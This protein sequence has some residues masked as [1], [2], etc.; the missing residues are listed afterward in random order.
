MALCV[1]PCLQAE[2]PTAAWRHSAI[3]AGRASVASLRTTNQV[4]DW[5]RTMRRN[6]SWEADGV[7]SSVAIQDG[8]GVSVIVNGKSD[9]NTTSDAGTTLMLGLLGP[10]TTDAPKTALVVGLGTGMTAGWLGRVPSIER[11][12]VAELEPAVVRVAQAAHEANEAV[13]QNPKV[14]LRFEDA[15][16]LLLT[17]RERYDLVVSEPSNPYRAGVASLFTAE[18]FAAAKAHLS[19]DG[20]LLQWLQAYEV[21]TVTLQSVLATVGSVFPYVDVWQTTGGDL[22][23]RGLKRPPAR[24]ADALRRKLAQPPFAAGVR[25]AWTTDSLEG[26]LAHFVA[27]DALVRRLLARPDRLLNTDDLNVVEFGFAR[28]VGAPDAGALTSLRQTALEAGADRPSWLAGDV[29]WSS[30]ARERVPLGLPD[31]TGALDATALARAR[32]LVPGQPSGELV[33]AWRGDPFAPVTL[34]ERLVLAR[35]LAEAG[36]DACLPLMAPLEAL[37]PAETAL[38]AAQLLAVRGQPDEAAQALMRAIDGWRRQRWLAPEVG[39]AGAA[40]AVVQALGEPQRASTAQLFAA[41]GSPFPAAAEETVRRELR[42]Q[43]SIRLASTEAC[44][45]AFGLFEPH[46]PWLGAFLSQR[47]DCYEAAHDARAALAREELRDFRRA[48]G[49]SGPDG[50]AVP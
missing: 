50:D 24:S 23:L 11:V 41:L 40:M 25:T 8:N 3:G 34:R 35:A 36:D 44:T 43:L 45:A 37:M 26:V 28:S 12:D 14:H 7:E 49:L 21:D 29:D 20:M 5:R 2:G 1:W 16:E 31:R 4:L 47:R 27:D 9:G 39:F 38:V 15:R 32:R 13:L 22:L 19:D 17:A 30:V 42:L 18:F 10:L 33:A 6:V 46:T 48:E